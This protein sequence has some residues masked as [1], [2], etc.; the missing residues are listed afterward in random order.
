MSSARVAVGEREQFVSVK[1]VAEFRLGISAGRLG[2]FFLPL[3]RLKKPLVGWSRT[4]KNFPG[5]FF[6]WL[7]A[8]PFSRRCLVLLLVLL[9]LS[10]TVARCGG[11]CAESTDFFVFHFVGMC[12]CN[13]VD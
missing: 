1:E 5:A 12:A 11:G 13:C 8:F 9:S 7:L 2:S 6:L 3:G 10:P 4:R